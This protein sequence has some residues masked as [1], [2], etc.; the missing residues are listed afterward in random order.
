MS[1]LP[2]SALAQAAAMV[3]GAAPC[4]AVQMMRDEERD[5]DADDDDG[6]QHEREEQQRDDIV[7]QSL[8]RGRAR[9]TTHGSGGGGG[10]GSGGGFHSAS[11]Q[12][13]GDEEDNDDDQEDDEEIT[14]LASSSSSGGGESFSAGA[15]AAAAAVPAVSSSLQ[16]SGWLVLEVAKPSK[17]KSKSK[18]KPVLPVMESKKRWAVLMRSFLFLAGRDKDLAH[19]KATVHL[20]GCTLS[21]ARATTAADAPGSPPP[22]LPFAFMLHFPAAASAGGSG[23]ARAPLT[24]TARSD[25]DRERW[26]QGLNDAILTLS[27][28][29]VLMS[30]RGRQIFDA[31]DARAIA[32]STAAIKGFVSEQLQRAERERS[33][34]AEL[35]A[36][37]KADVKTFKAQ[38]K[39]MASQLVA[40]SEALATGTAQCHALA[41][42]LQ[43]A[44]RE[45][46][47]YERSQHACFRTLVRMLDH[48]EAADPNRLNVRGPGPQ[49][50]ASNTAPAPPRSTTFSGGLSASNT[51]T[52]AGNESAVVPIPVRKG[53]NGG[54][55]AGAGA[56]GAG[57]ARSMYQLSTMGDDELADS[58]WA[59]QTT[60]ISSSLASSASALSAA[61]A[62]KS[63][64]TSSAKQP[65]K[66]KPARAGGLGGRSM[67]SANFGQTTLLSDATDSDDEEE[68]MIEQSNTRLAGLLEQI[69]S[70]P[71]PVAIAASSIDGSA[72]A[73]SAS[74]SIKLSSSTPSTS[75]SFLHSGSDGSDSLSRPDSLELQQV[76]CA[77]LDLLR[78]N[79]RLRLEQNTLTK[80]IEAWMK[81]KHAIA[82][83]RMN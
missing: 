35:V 79:L 70:L 53:G 22:H 13:R 63:K 12:Q 56:A 50:S 73:A 78:S 8:R 58:A 29:S 68:N 23:G 46:A 40:A 41:A 62:P 57:V 20:K 74:G 44:Q 61:P 76:Q 52:G 33:E 14:G 9:H 36:A 7:Q 32:E 59:P 77:V 3:A 72:G 39:L 82:L 43:Q 49:P 19:P 5:E 60:A 15:A 47:C 30:Y 10:G 28:P 66:L 69:N 71:E 45:A 65:Q 38:K 80:Y 31:E 51:N 2:A 75:S 48:M 42:Q 16:L 4:E 67:T 83:L 24:L 6:Q 1:S 21:L 18:S 37:K 11:S 26:M 55:G 64:S 27:V 34:L 17:S 25:A 54:A 81:R